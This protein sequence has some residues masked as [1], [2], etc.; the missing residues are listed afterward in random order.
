AFAV[1]ITLSVRFP[2]TL[3]VKREEPFLREILGGWRFITRRHGLVAL[4]VL[5]ASLNYFFSMVEV[6]VTPLTLSFG[7]PPVLRRVPAASGVGMVVGSVLMGVWGG[8]ARRTTGILA[9]VVLLGASLLTVG[10]RPSPLFPTLGL[11]GMGLA[12]A[13]VNT[14][15]LAIVQAK[16]GL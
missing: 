4:V 9:S 13:L 7:N 16:V 15:W 5:T 8:T 14:H 12:T 3:F 10:L 6:L 1:A 11:F 2:D